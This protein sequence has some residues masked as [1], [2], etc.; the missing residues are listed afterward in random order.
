MKWDVPGF[1]IKWEKQVAD[2]CIECDLLFI[3]K[4]KYTKWEQNQKTNLYKYDCMYDWVSQEKKMRKYT[5]QVISGVSDGEY[6]EG[7]KDGKPQPE[8]K[9]PQENHVINIIALKNK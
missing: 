1:I 7:G 5:H 4:T 6:I 3:N 8:Q 9:G 2:K